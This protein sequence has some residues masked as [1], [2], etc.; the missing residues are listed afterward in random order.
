ME[1]GMITMY[2]D[3]YTVP[4]IT[5]G[6]PMIYLCLMFLEREKP[7][8]IK[9]VLKRFAAWMAG[10][11]LMWIAKLTLTS[12]LTPVNAL[13][14]GFGAFAERVGIQKEESLTNYYSVET[15][16]KAVGE[17]IFSFES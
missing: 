13:V 12:A 8:R 7:I 3:F 10:Y 17:V 14:Q 4:L 5:F 11:G 1:V 9:W 2:F 16:S 6:L 15:A